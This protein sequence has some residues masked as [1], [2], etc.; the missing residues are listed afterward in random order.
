MNDT[1]PRYRISRYTGIL[2]TALVVIVVAYLFI[3]WG[4]PQTTILLV[5]HADWQGSTDTLSPAG[6]ARAQDLARVLAKSG[7]SAIYTSEAIRTQETAAPTA[8]QL[9]ITPLAVPAADVTGLVSTIRSSNS[10]Q[11]V[12]VVGHSNTVPQ[13]IAEFGGLTGTISETEFDNLGPSQ[14]RYVRRHRVKR[15]LGRA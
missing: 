5:R 2:A 12:L 14:Q 15:D 4:T 7:V 1:E 10:G 11:T 8:S 3:C 6:T 9:G 13:I